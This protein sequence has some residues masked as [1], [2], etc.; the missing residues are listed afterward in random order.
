MVLNVMNFCGERTIRA[1]GHIF[2]ANAEG[3]CARAAV[4]TPRHRGA[5]R[6]F[7]LARHDDCQAV[8]DLGWHQVHRR[9]A[10]ET[11]DERAVRCV[12]NLLRRADLHDAA[13]V[14][15]T[16]PIAHRHG[17]D[18]VMGDEQEGGA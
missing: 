12:V 6:Q 16:D 10:D 11:G 7:E 18:L 2:G 13:I 15:H 17:L 5:E 3:Q 14:Q 4:Q 8:T 9:R 1:D